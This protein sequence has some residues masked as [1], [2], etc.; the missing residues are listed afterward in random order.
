MKIERFE[1][2]HYEPAL[3]RFHNSV[4]TSQSATS[5]SIYCFG[6]LAHHLTANQ[7]IE[8]VA[9]QSAPRETEKAIAIDKSEC[10]ERVMRY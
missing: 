2:T 4:L 9:I 5:R 6:S 3:D 10:C 8:N 1:P 7:E